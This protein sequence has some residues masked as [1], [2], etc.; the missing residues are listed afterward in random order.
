MEATVIPVAERGRLHANPNRAVTNQMASISPCD[1]SDVGRDVLTG[2]DANLVSISIDGV[3]YTFGTAVDYTDEAAVEAA[4]VALLTGSGANRE[5]NVWVRAVYDADADALAIY[6]DGQRVINSLV[7]TGPATV[8]ATR[9]TTLATVCD[10]VIADA[11]GALGDV[12]YGDLSDTLANNP[13]A[14]SGTP[15]TDEATAADLIADLTAS[16]A[17]VGLTVAGAS[18]PGQDPVEVTVD[19]VESAYD[20]KFC[21]VMPS[22]DV[23]VTGAKVTATNCR[24]EIIS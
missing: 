16:L 5:Y 24:V 12:A 17:A 14:Y 10:Y 8:T 1:E 18:I 20:I 4:I 3:S 23:Y 7:K 6:H 15:L 2:I 22:A 13:Y 19:D 21:L 9:Y 11:V